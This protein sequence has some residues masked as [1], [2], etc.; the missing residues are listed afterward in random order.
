MIGKLLKRT[1]RN[2]EKGNHGNIFISIQRKKLAEN[3]LKLAINYVNLFE[4]FVFQR[5]NVTMTYHD[6]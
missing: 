4:F 6:F 1:K 2:L 3:H 5:I